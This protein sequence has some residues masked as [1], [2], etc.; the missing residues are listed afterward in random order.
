MGSNFAFSKLFTEVEGHHFLV[1]VLTADVECAGDDADEA[2]A[3]T[4]I[5]GAGGGLCDGGGDVNRGEAFESAGLVD[6]GAD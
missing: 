2:E 1:E 4:R 6:D 3:E 5:D